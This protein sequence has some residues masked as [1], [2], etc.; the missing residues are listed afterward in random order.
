MQLFCFA[1]SCSTVSQSE[2]GMDPSVVGSG[3]EGRLEV[4]G[5]EV[6]GGSSWATS[7]GRSRGQPLIRLGSCEVG[8]DE[9]S[10]GCSIKLERHGPTQTVIDREE[11]EEGLS[12]DDQRKRTGGAWPLGWS[13]AGYQT[14]EGTVFASGK[15]VG[16]VPGLDPISFVEGKKVRGFRFGLGPQRRDDTF[17]K[18]F[19]SFL[20]FLFSHLFLNT[21][22]FLLFWFFLFLFLIFLLSQKIRKKI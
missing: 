18:S 19:L 9:W 11:S 20:S 12:L 8:E 17:F 22:L 4:P 3:G 21:F 1:W 15:R 16:S 5:D 2:K 13:R 6:E 10:G 14:K 7:L